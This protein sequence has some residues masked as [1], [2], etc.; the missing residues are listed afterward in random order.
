MAP[1]V[2]RPAYAAQRAHPLP[3]SPH[4]LQ[5]SGKTLVALEGPNPVDGVWGAARP[6]APSV[7]AQVGK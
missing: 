7:S 5:A 2:H 4:A 3:T 1:V 6:A